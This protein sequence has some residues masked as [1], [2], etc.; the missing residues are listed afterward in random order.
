[1]QRSEILVSSG[2]EIEVN[3]TLFVLE[4]DK[5]SMEIP[6]EVP[7]VV[8]EV[9]IKVGDEIKTGQLLLKIESQLKDTKEKNTTI[10][11]KVERPPMDNETATTNVQML[12]EGSSYSG[13]LKAS[14]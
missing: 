3:Q 10:K 6:A 11:E 2:D 12:V 14:F 9:L 8:K 7:G 4:S 13:A 1:M 5:A